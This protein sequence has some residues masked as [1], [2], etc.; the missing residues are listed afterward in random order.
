MTTFAHIETG[1]AIDVLEAADISQYRRILN[2][3]ETWQ[4]V[5]VP[6][7]TPQ[8]AIPN[9]EGAYDKPEV[10][11]PVKMPVP[12]SGVAFIQICQTEGGMTDEQLVACYADA[13][14]K[15]LWIKFDR[16]PSLDRDDPRVQQGL[17]ALELAQYLA[18]GGAAAVTAAW[19]MA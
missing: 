3:P 15:A 11:E 7:G 17:A 4:I 12:I 14:F 10:P 2:A 13:A 19:P 9:G 8:G 18:V 1:R 16:S 6:D 5:D